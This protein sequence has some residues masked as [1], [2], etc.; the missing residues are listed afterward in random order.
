[1]C[2]GNRLNTDNTFDQISSKPLKDLYDIIDAQNSPVNN[3]CNY[4]SPDDI[5][6]DSVS[7][8]SSQISILHLNI[9]SVPSKLDELKALLSKLKSKNLTIDVILLCETFI[10]D[11]NKDS[12][13]LDDYELFRLQP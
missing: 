13:K 9:H 10:S 8:G 3:N 12:C 2:L 7:L 1:M 4:I 6:L 5:K 11:N